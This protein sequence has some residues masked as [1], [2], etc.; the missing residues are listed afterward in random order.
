MKDFL[1][2]HGF[3]VLVAENGI[4]A[5]E[6]VQQDKPDLLILDLAMPELDG[7]NAARRLREIPE[8]THLPILAITAHAFA[9]AGSRALEAGCNAYLSKPFRP[10]DVLAEVRRLLK[11]T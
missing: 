6:R 9:N 1:A 8:N 10:A 11:I 3:E 4:E 7:W 2:A 5:I